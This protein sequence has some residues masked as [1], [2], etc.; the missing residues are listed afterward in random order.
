MADSST[1]DRAEQAFERLA[2]GINGSAEA[3]DAARAQL[4]DLAAAFA[5]DAGQSAAA[6]RLRL[7]A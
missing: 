4:F 6:D 7:L 3:L 1:W 5:S 2:S